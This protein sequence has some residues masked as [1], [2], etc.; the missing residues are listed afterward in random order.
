VILQRGI[1]IEGE[2]IVT[3]SGCVTLPKISTVCLGILIHTAK[4]YRIKYE[5][6]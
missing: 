2:E 3:A 6:V 4:N 5:R 1:K